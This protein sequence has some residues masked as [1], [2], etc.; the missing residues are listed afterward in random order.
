MELKRSSASSY[1]LPGDLFLSLFQGLCSTSNNENT[2]GIQEHPAVARKDIDQRA[3]KVSEQGGLDDIPMEIVEL[4]AKNQY[5]RCLPDAE[6]DKCR[7]ETTNNTRSSQKMDFRKAYGHGEF[8]LFHQETTQIRNPRAKNGR[9]GITKKGEN[10]GRAKQKAVDYLSQPERNQCNITQLEQIHTP[11]GFGAFLQHQEKPSSGVQHCA[12][13]SSRQNSAQNCK[14]IGDVMGKRSSHPCLQ[15]SGPCN[16]CQNISLQSKEGNHIWS[17]MMPNPIPF[18]CGISQ[19]C[20][21]PSAAMDILSHSPGS[22]HKE[23][24]NGDHD[25]RFLNQNAANLGKPNRN[26][27]SETLSRTSAEYPFA[28]KQNGIEL[29]QKPIGSLDL[30]SNET[31][32][33]MHLLSLMDA[34]LRSSAPINMNVTP[35]ILKRPS[36]SHEHDPKEISRLDSGAYRATNTMKYPPYNYHGK[37]QLAENS[38]EHIPAVPT[39]VG[40]SASSFQHDKNF[41]MATDVTS[42]VVQDKGKRKGSD[43]HSQNKGFRSQKSA[44]TTGGLGTNCG[45]I[46]VHSMQTLFFGTS[47]S[48]IFP[49]PFHA[50]ENSTQQKLESRGLTR[51]VHPRKSSFETEICSVNR[52]PADFSAPEAGNMYMIA[53][54]DLKVERVAPSANRS[55][56]IKLDGHKRQ[57]KLPAVKERGRHLIA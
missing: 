29:N 12:S 28:C 20:A 57:R 11:A 15:A 19:K 54:E 24:M 30:Y 35:K 43:S 4:M 7:L 2:I 42:Q 21:A 52:N 13:S 17:S 8:D 56:L 44:S 1:C 3:D 36:I 18:V 38:R 40:A 27:G 41:K 39:M 10:V 49:L 45:S 55:G 51:A 48:M 31:I 50:L 34:G 23:S 22:M 26:L 9:N 47:D 16:A 5:E 37:N 14:W 53:G 32:P 46:P 6:H 25:M 33:A